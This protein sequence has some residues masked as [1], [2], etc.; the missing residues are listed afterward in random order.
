MHRNISPQFLGKLFESLRK[1]Y[2]IYCDERELLQ[3]YFYRYSFI[4]FNTTEL[5]Y[6]V[7]F[8]LI[9]KNEARCL[10]YLVHVNTVI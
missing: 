1:N 2:Y 8:L 5:I 7:L 3:H 4:C 6:I 10:F 9:K